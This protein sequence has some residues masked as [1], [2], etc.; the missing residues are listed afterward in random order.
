MQVGEQLRSI[1][2]GCKTA[3][4]PAIYSIK[5]SSAAIPRLVN[6]PLAP[7][8]FEGIFSMTPI[9]PDT[10]KTR[11]VQLVQAAPIGIHEE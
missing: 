10:E 6:P 11:R 1:P 7:R 2:E 3:H 9:G 8:D 5:E 4:Q